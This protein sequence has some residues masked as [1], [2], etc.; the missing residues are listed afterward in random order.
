[1]DENIAQHF[2]K[3]ELSFVN[4]TG[5]LINDVVNQYR[6]ILTKF[7][8][9]RERYITSS[10]VNRWNGIEVAY[11]G[12]YSDAEMVRGLIYPEYFEPTKDDFSVDLFEIKYPV[13]F[14]NLSHSQILGTLIGSGLERYTLGDI[15]T[16]GQRWQFFCVKEIAE[17]LALQI[18]RI[19]KVKVHLQ[20]IDLQHIITSNNEWKERFVTLSSFRLDNVISEGFNI[21]R[22]D[23]KNLINHQN[24]HLNWALNDQPDYVLDTNDVISV[25]HHGRL[26]LESKNGQTK[27]GKYR[28]ILSILKK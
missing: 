24:V 26:K 10:L 21:S 13:K 20:H 25:R 12:G 17:Y 4:T 9:P 6:P 11:F 3:E 7:L 18:T 15:L 28:V 23:A 1:M 19:G 14:A 22:G 2:K 27:K 5:D 8:N 16:D